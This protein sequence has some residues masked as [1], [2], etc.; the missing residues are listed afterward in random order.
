[1]T[2]ALL[3]V[4][5]ETNSAELKRE[6]KSSKLPQFRFYPN[7]KTGEEKHRASYEIVLPRDAD[8]VKEA[9]IEEI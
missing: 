3:V 6:F 7:L 4:D 2:V 8:K 1:M 9:V 5:P